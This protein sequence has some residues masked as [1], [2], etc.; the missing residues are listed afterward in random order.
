MIQIG[1]G[2]TRNCL[3]TMGQWGVTDLCSLG[4]LGNLQRCPVLLRVYAVLIFF[5]KTFPIPRKWNFDIQHYFDPTKRS[6]ANSRGH[7]T[8]PFVFFQNPYYYLLLFNFNPYKRLVPFSEKPYIVN[9]WMCQVS[10]AI[11]IQYSDLNFCQVIITWPE[12]GIA[13]AQLVILV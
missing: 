1:D 6:M 8:T 13:Q 2:A 10:Q 9:R 11:S 12:L 3:A 7:V 5:N 4:C